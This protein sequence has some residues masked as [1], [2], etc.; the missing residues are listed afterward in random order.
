MYMVKYG[1]L[2][3]SIALHWEE[4]R[5]QD[6]EMVVTTTSHLILHL[7]APLCTVY[8]P[9]AYLP[10]F[11]P[12]KEAISIPQIFLNLSSNVLVKR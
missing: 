2:A 7:G 12:W 3:I 10:V 8:K 9:Q 4:H 6:A 5:L 11:F 1:A